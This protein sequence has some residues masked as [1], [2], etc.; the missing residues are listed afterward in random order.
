MSEKISKSALFFRVKKIKPARTVLDALRHNKRTIQAELAAFGN[1]D[2][3][4]TPMNYSLAG[5]VTP[6]AGYRQVLDDI[7]QYNLH[8]AAKIRH[9]AVVAIEAVFSVPASRTD[10]NT[11]A[12]FKQCLG[13]CMNEFDRATLI[14]ADVHL[15]EANPHM[16]VLMGCVSPSQLFGSC[17]VGFA[18]KF[19]HRNQR[20]FE[21]VGKSFGLEVPNAGLSKRDR[22]RLSHQVRLAL[23]R[24][25]DPVLRS[26]CFDSICEAIDANPTPFALNLDIEFVA[27]PKPTKKLRTVVQSF[28]S[29]GKG[30]SRDK[31]ETYPV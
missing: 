31:D 20:F 29:K 4:R 19:S 24:Q 27:S 22:K 11:Q 15:D 8:R 3:S 6:E 5:C 28:T 13:W 12:F 7:N 1:I 17:A 10:I 30:G 23:Q 21:E 9:D 2:P 14:S 25:G 18:G 16:H 26:K